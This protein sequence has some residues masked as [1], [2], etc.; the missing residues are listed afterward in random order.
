MNVDPHAADY[1]DMP[2]GLLG[3][4]VDRDAARREARLAELGV[5][6]TPD[7][8]LDALARELADAARELVGAPETPMAMVNFIDREQQY[9]AGLYVPEATP[10]AATISTSVKVG[11]QMPLDH[12]WCPHVVVRGTAFPLHDVCAYPR[13]VGN[14]VISKVGIRSYLG[15]PL[16]EPATGMTLGTI[17]VIARQPLPWGDSGVA[18]IKQKAAEAVSVITSRQASPEPPRP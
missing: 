8:H 1:V 5:S 16:I 15:A 6:M 10:A 11:R 7:G 17:C 12:G 14:P 3:R 13:F 18:L 2:A 9:F 4:P